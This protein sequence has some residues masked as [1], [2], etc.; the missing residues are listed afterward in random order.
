MNSTLIFICL[1]LILVVSIAV[2]VIAREK[3]KDP[4][5]IYQKGM[6]YYRG[7][8]YTEAVKYFHEAAV[9]CHENA[10]YNLGVCFY[11]GIGVQQDHTKA[12]AWFKVAAERNDPQ[13]QYNLAQCYEYGDGVSRDYEQAVFWFTK[14]AGHG[15]PEAQNNLGEH[16]YY[17]RGIKQD[18]SRAV[19][20]YSKSAEQ[21]LAMGQYN[22]SVCYSEG[23]GVEQDYEKAFYWIKKAAEQGFEVAQYNVGG[24]YYNG[25]GVEQDYELAVDWYRKAAEQ[26]YADAQYNLGVCYINGTGVESNI[27]EA[28][29]WIKKAAEQG[30][31]D[32]K[33]ALNLV[34]RNIERDAQEA[35]PANQWSKDFGVIGKMVVNE[36]IIE[37]LYGDRYAYEKLEVTDFESSYQTFLNE[38]RAVFVEAPYKKEAYMKAI[39]LA[40]A[41]N[42]S[43]SENAKLIGAVDLLVKT[44]NGIEAY[45]TDFSSSIL[46]LANA[47]QPTLPLEFYRDKGVEGYLELLKLYKEMGLFLNFPA[48]SDVLI[49]GCGSIGRA[50]AFAAR[51]MQFNVRLLDSDE[52]KTRQLA[53]E[54]QQLKFSLVPPE[55]SMENFVDLVRE[56]DIIIYALPDKLDEINNLSEDDLK[57]KM[58]QKVII[59]TAPDVKPFEEL[60]YDKVENMD[61]KYINGLTWSYFKALSGFSIMTGEIPDF[62]KDS[63]DKFVV[64]SEPNK[65]SIRKCT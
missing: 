60:I 34:G 57:N 24:C 13:A 33:I 42:G 50:A 62:L 39:E 1:A 63:T 41:G 14:A 22:L 4:E 52:N 27:K 53:N 9:A 2:I 36:Q 25:K 44:P 32:A 55:Q 49:I 65:L 58:G 19:S 28:I 11:N 10:Q 18:F 15:M 31:G 37:S 59:E 8:N 12:V 20:L 38:Y 16:Y 46:S 51:Q 47:S 45:N 64:V 7:G 61:A 29:V 40:E 48:T 54:L 35:V 26:G 56:S 5:E 3:G 23:N 6:T 17:G 30:H 21:G 43:I